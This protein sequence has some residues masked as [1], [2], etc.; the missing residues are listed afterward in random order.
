MDVAEN[1]TDEIAAIRE[2]R[3]QRLVDV[4]DFAA[5]WREHVSR[6]F[7]E[8]ANQKL[9]P[10]NL[11]SRIESTRRQYADLKGRLDESDFTPEV[12]SQILEIMLDGLM[13]A[14]LG[15]DKA[16]DLF[17]DLLIR[18]ESIRRLIR[19]TLDDHVFQFGRDQRSVTL[20]L[21][22]WLNEIPQSER[23]R[24]LNISTKQLGRWAA[25]SGDPSERLVLVASLVAIL[26]RSWSQVGILA[27]FDRSRRELGDLTPLEFLNTSPERPAILLDLARRGL[28]QRAT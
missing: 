10:K 14:D 24:L 13:K 27:W 12:W 3:R 8:P 22:D 19:D 15:E 7:A 9:T 25:G 6:S 17:E 28:S 23:A 16:I 2:E 1:P 20:Q 21:N 18:I 5:E 11:E 4:K 26:H